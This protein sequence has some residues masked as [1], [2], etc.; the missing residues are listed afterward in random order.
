MHRLTSNKR[1]NEMVQVLLS[2]GW[3]C[4]R[5]KRHLVLQHTATGARLLLPCTIRDKGTTA[6]NYYMTIRRAR[7]RMHETTDH[8]GRDTT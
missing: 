3:T 5:S 4:L 8:E 6:E 7:R 2:E 1:L